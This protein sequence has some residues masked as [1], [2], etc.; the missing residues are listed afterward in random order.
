MDEARDSRMED[1]SGVGEALPLQLCLV[2]EQLRGDTELQGVCRTFQVGQ[3]CECHC[4][5]PGFLRR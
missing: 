4:S 5:Q 1:V 2:G 3:G